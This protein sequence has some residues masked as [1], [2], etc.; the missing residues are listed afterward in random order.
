M[1]RSLFKVSRGIIHVS[2]FAKNLDDFNGRT[3]NFYA[4][5]MSE[6]NDRIANLFTSPLEHVCRFS[7]YD[8][9]N[10]KSVLLKVHRDK[11]QFLTWDN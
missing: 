2:T 10:H 9:K 4:C 3:W 1:W 8:V 7:R 6:I 11:N 5:Q